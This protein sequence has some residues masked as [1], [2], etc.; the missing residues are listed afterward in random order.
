MGAIM[1]LGKKSNKPKK[2]SLFDYVDRKGA[3]VGTV[4]AIGGAAVYGKVKRSKKKKD[5]K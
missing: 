1:K 5:K 3:G 4:G 2:E